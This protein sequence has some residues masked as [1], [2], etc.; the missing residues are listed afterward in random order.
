MQFEAFSG[1]SSCISGVISLE[2][3]IRVR[4][5]LWEKL[6]K[7]FRLLAN[8]KSYDSVLSQLIEGTIADNYIFFFL[9]VKEFF[10]LVISERKNLLL[11]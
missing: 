1:I 11:G 6:Y 4:N 5:S 3:T 9:L 7:K 8:H 2:I 10:I